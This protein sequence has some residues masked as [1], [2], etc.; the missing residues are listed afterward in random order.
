MS[1]ISE[2]MST[3]MTK[4][5]LKIVLYARRK[6]AAHDNSFPYCKNFSLY[7][8]FFFDEILFAA[9]YTMVGKVWCL[10]MKKKSK[11]KKIKEVQKRYTR[12]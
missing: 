8:S 9:I 2:N 4:E 12:I 5:E 6:L 7:P 11:C 3:F 10:R 1:L